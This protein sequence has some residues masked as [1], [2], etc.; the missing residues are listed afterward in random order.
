M[1]RR[2]Y[3]LPRPPLRGSPLD[4]SWQRQ[5]L[6]KMTRYSTRRRNS[7]EACYRYIQTRPPPPKRVRPH[8]NGG[9]KFINRIKLVMIHLGEDSAAASTAA[10]K[11]SGRPNRILHRRRRRASSND[12]HRSKDS[13]ATLPRRRPS[14]RRLTSSFSHRQRK[15]SSA[16]AVRALGRLCSLRRRRSRISSHPRPSP[17]LPRGASSCKVH[18]LRCTHSTCFPWFD[19]SSG[20]SHIRHGRADQAL[21]SFAHAHG[22]HLS[23]VHSPLATSSPFF[24]GLPAYLLSGYSDRAAQLS[25]SP[26]VIP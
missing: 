5:G 19:L 10:S 23:F 16:T 1:R 7:M 18:T 4:L 20:Q 14:S 17:W 3:R 22:L 8:I 6:H 26:V 11:T 9:K 15:R 24:I 12:T 2:R 21:D 13:K 25:L